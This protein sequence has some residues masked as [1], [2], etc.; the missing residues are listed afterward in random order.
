MKINKMETIN[1]KKRFEFYKDLDNY[2]PL[3]IRIE[4]YINKWTPF[5]DLS[6]IDFSDKKDIIHRS[7]MPSEIIIDLDK[8]NIEDNKQLLLTY[9]QLLEDNK[10]KYYV[11]YSG[12][13]GFHIHFYFNDYFKFFSDLQKK[14][15]L[16]L[17]INERFTLI[18]KGILEFFKIDLNNIDLQ[19]IEIPRKLIRAEGSKHPNGYFKTFLGSYCGTLSENLK[20]FQSS[21][22]FILDNVKISSKL[23]EMSE[24]LNEYLITKLNKKMEEQKDKRRKEHFNTLRIIKQK[25]LRPIV[26]DLLNKPLE[27]GRKVILFIIIRELIGSKIKEEDIKDIITKWN[28]L[29]HTQGS[30]NN[31][32]IYLQLKD[33]ISKD[34]KPL[35]TETINQYLNQVIF[36]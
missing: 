20:T 19:I 3:E 15:V 27:D 13:K 17:E 5:K 8:P 21:E 31:N 16:S 23:N 32:F 10:I 18:K 22:G 33:A 11:Y 35:K 9:C 26:K 36:K 14:Q 25:G 30:L 6:I 24:T 1:I 7:I 4:D 2:E 29:N 34:V 28:N 12:G